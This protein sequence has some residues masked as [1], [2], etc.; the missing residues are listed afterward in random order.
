MPLVLDKD[1]ANVWQV[2]NVSTHTTNPLVTSDNSLGYR[3]GDVWL[4]S[5]TGASWTNISNATG[6]AVWLQDAGN[7]IH[8]SLAVAL[9][10]TGTSRTDALALTA[11]TNQVTV[12]ATTTGV[13]LPPSA[14]VG[15]GGFCRVYNDNGANAIHVYAASSTLI[16]STAGIDW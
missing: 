10:A 4:N 6:A 2:P 3:P 5:S 11:Q 15:V 12:G 16:G 9:T 13:V 7:F 1:L 8:G 14:T